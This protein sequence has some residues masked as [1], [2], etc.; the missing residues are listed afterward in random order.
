MLQ[1]Y[2]YNFLLETTS[3]RRPALGVRESWLANAE[4]GSNKA[5]A[6]AAA[7]EPDDD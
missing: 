7:V 4:P 5:A 2:N 3:P 1:H 6:A